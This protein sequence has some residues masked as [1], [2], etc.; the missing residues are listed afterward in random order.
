MQKGFQRWASSLVSALVWY[1][2]VKDEAKEQ[3]SY[4]TIFP[5]FH[6]NPM[7]SKRQVHTTILSKRGLFSY[8]MTGF[9]FSHFFFFFKYKPLHTWSEGFS[10]V[11]SFFS[12]WVFISFLK[13][14]SSGSSYASQSI[15]LQCAMISYLV[16][17]LYVMCRHNCV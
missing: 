13:L 8:N 14:Y 10:L 9:F 15:D 16:K 12:S 11:I 3:V 17:I 1:R 4:F 6:V 5:S 7:W 2:N